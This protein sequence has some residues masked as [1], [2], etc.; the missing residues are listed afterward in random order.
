MDI[1]GNA[2]IHVL[3]IICNNSDTQYH[4]ELYICVLCIS[5]PLLKCNI[6]F[7]VCTKTFINTFQLTIYVEN[8]AVCVFR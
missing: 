2:Q 8:F 1:S 4:N 3:Q 5:N 6:V 7:W